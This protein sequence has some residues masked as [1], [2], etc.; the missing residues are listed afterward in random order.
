MSA[1]HPKAD[2]HQRRLDVRFV[3][4]GNI[5]P[6]PGALWTYVKDRDFQACYRP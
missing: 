6:I 2:I 4:Q 5:Q 1:I 3:P